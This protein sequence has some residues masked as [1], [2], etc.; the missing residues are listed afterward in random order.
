MTT[1]RGTA[2]T[3][4]VGLALGVAIVVCLVTGLISHF[5]QHPQPWFFW[6]TRPVWLYRFTQ[7]L[8]VISG[9]AAIPLI[10]VKLWS[11]WPKLFERPLIG[12]LVRQLERASI[13][14]LVASML[15]QLSTGLMNIT[16]WYAFRF[17]F[18]TAH[19]AMAYVAAGAV[20]VHIAVKLPVIRR[21]LG[22]PLEDIP[23]GQPTGL[24]RRTV[25]RSA[26]F[27][28]ALGTVVTAGQTVPLLRRVSVL[29]PRSGQGPQGVPVNRSAIA[30]GVLHS[31]RAPQYRLTVANGPVSRTFGIDEL[32]AMPQSTHRLPIA[33]VEGWSADAEWTG[34][35]L[36]DLVAAV[37]GTPDDDVRMISLEPPGPY[38]RTTLPA[39]HARDT[40]T[41]I[42]LRL[43]GETLDLDHGYP[44]RLIAATRPGVLQTKWLSRIEIAR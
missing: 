34:V 40:R 32:N 4:R 37:G 17:F 14:V 35:P 15:F 23:S 43:N 38:S 31:A 41:L 25:L 24:T 18:T 7:G 2:V 1:L 3:A 27:A 30:A 42:A 6:P 33:C 13:L 10:V 28:V 36:A 11:V 16:Q 5:I 8:H 19:Y 9:I 29:A 20:L 21:A 44:C 12:G 39:R 26:W 22:E